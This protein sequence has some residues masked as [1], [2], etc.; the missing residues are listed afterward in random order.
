MRTILQVCAVSLL[1]AWP[2]QGS[3]VTNFYSG[4]LNW[5]IPDNDAGGLV[6]SINVS[7][8]EGWQITDVNLTL[9]I[10]GGWNGDFYSYLVHDYTTTA[11]LLNRVGRDGS[12]DGFGGAGLSVTL[13]DTAG[14]LSNPSGYND[15]HL[16]GSG[17]PVTGTY[18]PDGRLVDPELVANGTPRT[19]MLDVFNGQLAIGNWSLF[20]S[21]LGPLFEGTL[22]SWGLEMQLA[23][24]PEPGQI[25]ASATLLTGIGAYLLHQRRRRRMTT[26]TRM[27]SGPDASR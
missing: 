18:S 21:D 7:G 5:T 6:S 23:A 1:L 8:L 17:S 3:L 19:A 4:T 11:V 13:D 20:L 9:N 15:I 10:D 22:V 24:V 2:G 25:L 16:Y 12:G 26:P 14:S 27:D